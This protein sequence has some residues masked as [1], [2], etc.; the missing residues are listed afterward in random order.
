MFAVRKTGPA[1][2]SHQV[3]DFR[4]QIL[5]FRSQILSLRSQTY[6]RSKTLT[7][8]FRFQVLNFRLSGT[9]TGPFAPLDSTLAQ[10]PHRSTNAGS[11]EAFKSFRQVFL[12]RPLYTWTGRSAQCPVQVTIPVTGPATRGP[13]RPWAGSAQV[14]KMDRSVLRVTNPL[15]QVLQRGV[16]EALDG[17]RRRSL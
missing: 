7:C 5:N 6:F 3:L 16:F 13:L 9:C 15:T 4:R 12:T 2:G 14:R 11:L 8:N 17:F 1:Y 10:V